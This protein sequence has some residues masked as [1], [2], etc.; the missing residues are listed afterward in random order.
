MSLYLGLDL[1]TQS[2]SASVYNSKTMMVEQEISINFGQMVEIESSKIDKKTLLIPK[3]EGQAEQD[4][5]IFLMAIDHLLSDLIKL[6]DVQQI[7]GIQFSAQQHGHV[8]LNNSFKDIVK[9]LDINKNLWGNLYKTFSYDGAPIWRSCDTEQE[10]NELRMSVGG[11]EQIIQITGSNSPLRFTGAIIKKNFNHYPEVKKNTDQIL[12]LN[13]YLAAIFSGNSNPKVDIGNGSGMT[14][15]DYSLKSWNKSLLNEVD[16]SFED[17]LG[18]LD[19]PLSIAGNINKYFVDKYGFSSKCLIGIGTGDNPATKVLCQGDLLSLGTSF[20]Y[21]KNTDI[22]DRDK[23]GVSNAMYDGMGNSFMILC[24][25]NGALIWDRIRLLYNKDY[26]E[27]HNAL[28][29][30]RNKYPLSLWQIERESV[31]L[32]TTIDYTDLGDFEKNYK[33]L[34]LSS[35]GL[36]EQYTMIFGDQGQDLSITGGATRDNEIVQIIAD[37]WQC[38]VHILPTLG[39]SLGAAFMAVVMIEKEFSL[40]KAQQKLVIETVYPQEEEAN[41]KH[42]KVALKKIIQSYLID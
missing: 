15:M 26:T 38:P 42:Y 4:P 20:V 9:N 11:K 21:M 28:L 6:I 23:S 3:K 5:M 7:N 34:I 17:K 13:T 8:Y 35:L 39:A 25:T 14:L 19:H 16:H 22:Q 1:S 40:H 33:A 29:S 37:L 27:S 31:P 12:L 41:I 24:R 10:A 30:Q 2:M 18:N 36:L 32:S